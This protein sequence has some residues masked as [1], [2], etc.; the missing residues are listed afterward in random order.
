MNPQCLTRHRK[1]AKKNCIDLKKQINA[2]LKGLYDTTLESHNTDKWRNIIQ[3]QVILIVKC[4]HIR[5]FT[6]LGVYQR[7]D[8]IVLPKIP[9]LIDTM[10][11]ILTS[12]GIIL[13][14]NIEDNHIYRIGCFQE[15]KTS[16]VVDK[17]QMKNGI[18]DN[19][20]YNY[21]AKKYI[22]DAPVDFQYHCAPH[23][24]FKQPKI[25]RE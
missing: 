20:R 1:L 23:K 16:D 4:H 12:D 14:Y 7:P 21:Q 18:I 22:K 9:I 11:V 13:Q 5:D 17:N 10:I 19:R 8:S 15:K 24:K 2:I 6:I 3:E 25:T